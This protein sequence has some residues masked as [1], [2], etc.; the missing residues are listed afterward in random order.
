MEGGGGD[1][2]CFDFVFDSLL[3]LS[4]GCHVFLFG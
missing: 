4:P 2:S 3:L 1:M